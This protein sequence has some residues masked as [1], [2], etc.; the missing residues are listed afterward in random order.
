MPNR[1]YMPITSS[2]HKALRASKRKRV[3]NLRI[4]AAVDVPMKKFKKLISEK[5]ID[6]AKS[7]V[8]SI[9]KA[10][11]KGAKKNYIKANTAS[12]YKSRVMMALKRA[13]DK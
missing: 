3:Y 6:E 5:K 9:Y 2:A 12:R 13:Q 1:L 10:L 8:A 4:K 7:L 11:D